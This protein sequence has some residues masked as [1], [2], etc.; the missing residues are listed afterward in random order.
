MRTNQATGRRWTGR[1]ARWAGTAATVLAVAA[2]TGGGVGN[3]AATAEHPNMPARAT[4]DYIGTFSNVPSAPK[5]TA[6]IGGKISVVVTTRSTTTSMSAT[7]LDATSTYIA[8]V[9]DQACFVGEGGGRFLFD[10]AG[11]KTPPNAIWLAPKINAAGNGTATTTS[12]APAGPRAK[13]IVLH[14]LRAAGAKEDNPNAPKLA[15]ADI[16]RVTS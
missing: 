13:S 3:A 15:C 8:D 4:F 5:G 6:P 14:L 16:V 1:K 7:G 12:P 11:P 10:P 9:H 2:A